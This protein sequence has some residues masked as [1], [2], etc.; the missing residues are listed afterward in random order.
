MNNKKKRN[1]FTA[2]GCIALAIMLGVSTYISLVVLGV[3]ADADSNG[4]LVIVDKNNTAQNTV[5][6]N[7]TENNLLNNYL[8]NNTL[9]ESAPD[10]NAPQDNSQGAIQTPNPNT[11]IQITNTLLDTN[12]SKTDIIK[13]YADVMNTAKAQA[14]GFTKVEYQEFPDGPEYRVVTEGEESIDKV[15]GFVDSLG[16][17]ATKEEAE[18]DPYIHQKG[19][20]DMSLF[21]VFNMPKGS[22]LT[23]PEAIQSYTYKIL[24]NGNVKMTFVLVSEV[25][26]EPIAAGSEVAPSYTGAV[27]S[28]MSKAKIDN[29]VNHPIVGAFA[30]DIEYSLRYHD[31]RVELE[32][33]PNNLQIINVLHVANVTLKGSGNVVLGGKMSL[34]KQELITTMLIRDVVY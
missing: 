24:P 34:E 27:F 5:N 1:I 10:Y 23:E 31:C 33:N 13:I 16:L 32:F 14:P 17:I 11:N 3:F 29:T 25:G 2:L 9:N 28:P 7:T 30:K 21:P 4:S 15:F 6:E 26:P 12:K 18:K 20:A 8:V 19:D 22:Y